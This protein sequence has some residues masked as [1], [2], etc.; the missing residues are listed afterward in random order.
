MKKSVWKKILETTVEI[1]QIS[2]PTINK[3]KLKNVLGKQKTTLKRVENLRLEKKNKKKEER[4]NMLRNQKKDK[5]T[6]TKNK[7]K[8][9]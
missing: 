6:K 4:K 1:K 7:G 8:T 2:K 3:K 5:I 9:K